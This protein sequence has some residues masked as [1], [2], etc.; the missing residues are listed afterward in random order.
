[1]LQAGSRVPAKKGVVIA[2]SPP[3]RHR[4]GNTMDHRGTAVTKKLSKIKL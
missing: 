4:A 3:D 1:M 2:V